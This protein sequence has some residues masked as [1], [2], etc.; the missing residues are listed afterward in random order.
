M[1]EFAKSPHTI[2]QTQHERQCQ[3][4]NASNSDARRSWRQK[5]ED[6]L[7]SGGQPALDDYKKLMDQRR[8]AASCLAEYDGVNMGYAIL[9]RAQCRFNELNAKGA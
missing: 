8:K 5:I 6:D 9:H 2:A 4:A 3:E 1:V 7:V